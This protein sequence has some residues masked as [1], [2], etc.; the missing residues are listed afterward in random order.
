MRGLAARWPPR[1][2]PSVTNAM[3]TASSGWTAAQVA[4]LPVCDVPGEW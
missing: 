3:V 1:P 2:G 4:G